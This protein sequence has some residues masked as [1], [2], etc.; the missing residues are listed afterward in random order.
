M[1]IELLERE[2]KQHFVAEVVLLWLVVLRRRV[3]VHLF[4]NVVDTVISI[5]CLQ[6]QVPASAN[7]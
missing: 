2:H 5:V 3:H 1:R 6:I 7:S 4:V